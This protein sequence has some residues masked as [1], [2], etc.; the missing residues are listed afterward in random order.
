M[1]ASKKLSKSARIDVQSGKCI[2]RASFLESD[3]SMYVHISKVMFCRVCGIRVRVWESYRTSRSFGYGYG[4]VTEL[5]EVPDIV[6]RAYITH[7]SS[8]RVQTCCT[9]T[10]G[11]VKR[12]VQN[13]QKFRVRVWKYYRTSRSRAR[14]RKCYR[15]SR[16]FG[17]CGTGI[18]NLTE[19][20]G[21]YENAV[22]VPR[23]FV[24]LTY[25]TYR[26]SGYG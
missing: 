19:V 22:P 24:A 10:P 13:S 4:S 9:R 14:V 7:R 20:P 26:S 3:T 11:I 18:Q 5:T 25:R 6:A 16:S 2:A 15:S 23:V 17:Y 1:S 21:R 8:R 12:V